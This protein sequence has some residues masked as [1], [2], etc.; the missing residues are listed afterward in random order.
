MTILYTCH[1][2]GLDVDDVSPPHNDIMDCIRGLQADIK[3]ANAEIESV[4]QDNHKL[5][6]EN[7]LLRHNNAEIAKLLKLGM[8]ACKRWE[9]KSDG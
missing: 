3:A 1:F 6:N 2:C 7:Y 5:K 9:E 8:D 4:Y